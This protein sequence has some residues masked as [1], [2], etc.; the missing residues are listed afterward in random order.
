MYSKFQ[1]WVVY[2]MHTHYVHR[3]LNYHPL[4][5]GIQCIVSGHCHIPG[6]MET[7][8]EG[9]EDY[10]MD[11]ATL[12]ECRIYKLWGN[13]SETYAFNQSALHYTQWA[14]YGP[15]NLATT[16]ELTGCSRCHWC[17]TH[18]TLTQHTTHSAGEMAG[19][20]HRSLKALSDVMHW[21]NKLLLCCCFYCN[22]SPLILPLA[23][24]HWSL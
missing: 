10:I 11:T 21:V 7:E 9:P 12:D 16:Q 18:C 23:K 17:H 24:L 14:P 3:N 19:C 4:Q 1:Y 8:R 13:L 2:I 15:Q 20:I 22:L 6:S 5:P